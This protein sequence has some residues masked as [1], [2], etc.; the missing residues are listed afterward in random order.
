MLNSPK[1]SREILDLP[2]ETLHELTRLFEVQTEGLNPLQIKQV[3]LLAIW[4]FRLRIMEL[5]EDI[6]H[7]Q[8]ASEKR[9]EKGYAYIGGDI[10]NDRK[11]E[12]PLSWIEVLEKQHATM[13]SWPLERWV[14]I[15]ILDTLAKRDSESYKNLIAHSSLL[16]PKR[17]VRK[18]EVIKIPRGPMHSPLDLAMLGIP[19]KVRFLDEPETAIQR[20][21]EAFR[22]MGHGAHM[23]NKEIDKRVNE[24]VNPRHGKDPHMPPEMFLFPETAGGFIMSDPLDTPCHM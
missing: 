23:N 17:R 22:R 8:H 12:D 6:L 9:Y 18:G 16:P 5:D 15:K 1:L 19:M 20:S 3:L 10:T 21:I 24:I 4:D 7:D 2:E 14:R 13:D 11:N